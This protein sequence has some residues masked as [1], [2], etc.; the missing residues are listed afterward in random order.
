M[1]E[2]PEVETVRRGLQPHIEGQTIKAVH[3]ARYD[4]R[5]PIPEDLGQRLTGQQISSVKRRGKLLLWHLTNPS[6]AIIN[7]ETTDV[8][9]I[10][11]GMSGRLGISTDLPIQKHD[12][13][14]I[15]L[16]N[17]EMITF[18]DPRRFGFFDICSQGD[19]ALDPLLSTMGPEPLEDAF[20]GAALKSQ[21][22]KRSAPLK[23][24]LLDQHIV[25]GLGN[26]YVCEALYKSKIAPD[27][28][29][30][31][32]SDEDA[33]RLVMAI[34]SV[35]QRA[36]EVGGSTLKDHRK[37]DGSTGYFQIEFQ[38]YGRDQEPC[39]RH[40]DTPGHRITK[41]VQSGRSTFYCPACQK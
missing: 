33:E 4:L 18:N 23:N 9:L 29:A 22:G 8:V 28:P 11:L 1:P 25:A 41:K 27:R 20:T 38:A 37:P 24:I 17:G 3:I 7:D 21:I 39:P 36:I 13:I 15:E 6:Q 32:L 14:R 26:I 19:L 40:P 35:L 16:N 31:T 30:S 12:H 10:H 2:L 5:R 34:R